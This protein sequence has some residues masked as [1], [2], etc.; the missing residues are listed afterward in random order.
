[1]LTFRDGDDHVETLSLWKKILTSF[2]YWD[3]T[4]LVAQELGQYASRCFGTAGLLTGRASIRPV[5][6]RNSNFQWFFGDPA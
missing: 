4:L 3:V 6:I 1:V 2:G 5:K